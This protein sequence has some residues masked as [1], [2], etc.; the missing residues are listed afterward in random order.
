MHLQQSVDIT[1]LKTAR[2]DRLTGLF[3][4]RFGKDRLREAMDRATAKG[5]SISVCLF[6]INDLKCVNEST[7][8]QKA[9]GSSARWRLPSVASSRFPISASG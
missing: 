3:T 7:A 6:D 1:E 4:R 8:T 2:I 9:T 5:E